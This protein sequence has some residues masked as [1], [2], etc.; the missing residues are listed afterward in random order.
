MEGIEEI[1]VMLRKDESSHA[2]SIE[3]GFSL[4][5]YL[6]MRLSFLDSL[7]RCAM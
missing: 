7:V 6:K 1:D 2:F 3:I 4:W 5:G